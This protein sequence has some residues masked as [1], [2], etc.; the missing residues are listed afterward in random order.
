MKTKIP[1]INDLITFLNTKL[2]KVEFKQVGPRTFYY[3]DC[4]DTIF[5]KVDDK[6]LIILTDGE[7]V[8]DTMTIIPIVLTDKEYFDSQYLQPI[9]TLF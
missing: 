7:N 3:V 8:I 2:S 1:H 4:V 6:Q 9:L 5:V